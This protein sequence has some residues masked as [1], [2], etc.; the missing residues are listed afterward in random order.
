MYTHKDRLNSPTTKGCIRL[1]FHQYIAIFIIFPPTSS[2]LY[3]LQVENSNSVQNIIMA[4]CCFEKNNVA[5]V[6]RLRPVSLRIVFRLIS[7]VSRSFCHKCSQIRSRN[8]V[9]I[10]ATLDQLPN[11]AS[12]SPVACETAKLK[13]NCCPLWSRQGPNSAWGRNLL[14][15]VEK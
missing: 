11:N 15:R 14:T 9:S 13:S 10:S 8:V 1:L 2:H 12:Y 3:P 5:W 6:A 7:P 4:S